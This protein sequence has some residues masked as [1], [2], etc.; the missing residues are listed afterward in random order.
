[1]LFLIC[2]LFRHI[3][4]TSNGCQ[5]QQGEAFGI[6]YSQFPSKKKERKKAVHLPHSA[7]VLL[8]HFTVC[9]EVFASIFRDFYACCGYA[10]SPINRD[11]GRTVV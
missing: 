4:L 8:P 6:I 2:D 5:G 7:S 3:Q 11:C 9:F 10:C 1:M